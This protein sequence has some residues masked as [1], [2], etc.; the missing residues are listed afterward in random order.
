MDRRLSGVDRTLPPTRTRPRLDLSRVANLL[1][2]AGTVAVAAAIW[3]AGYRA[4]TYIIW[5]AAHL[6]AG[7]YAGAWNVGYPLAY[8]YSPALA[9]ALWPTTLLP[10]MAVYLLWV[11][12]ETAL[13]VWMAGPLL[14]FFGILF[15]LPIQDEILSGNIN[16]ML[17]AVAVLGFRYPALWAFALLTKITPG[18]GVLWFAVRGEW[19]KLGIALAVTAAVALASALLAPDLW[20]HW[21]GRLIES[22]GKAPFPLIPRLAIGA[23]L[24]AIG[25]RR[26]WYWTV[27]FA[28]ALV[29][30]NF[31]VPGLALSAFVGVLPFLRKRHV[32]T[33]D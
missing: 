14:A 27:P 4:D 9:Q 12:L 22:P 10:F 23:V 18:I 8:L 33:R 1:A 13:L 7:M 17:A 11:A 15:V 3:W 5:W 24:I 19:R 29:T 31:A 16:L 20:I 25:A 6:P 32:W 21:I 30:P 26:D 28:A 2:L